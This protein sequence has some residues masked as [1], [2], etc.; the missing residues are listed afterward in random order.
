MTYNIIYKLKEK[1][2]GTG[3][4]AK[5]LERTFP[6]IFKSYDIEHEQIPDDNRVWR[7]QKPYFYDY[8]CLKRIHD[9]VMCRREYAKFFPGIKAVDGYSYFKSDPGLYRVWFP[10]VF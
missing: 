6:D 8:P 9:I 2:V 3:I 4:T 10:T 7:L 5:R 1:S